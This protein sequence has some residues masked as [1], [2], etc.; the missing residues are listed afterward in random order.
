MAS[1]SKHVPPILLSWM[2]FLCIF[3]AVVSVRFHTHQNQRHRLLLC[4]SMYYMYFSF[5]SLLL[6]PF[7]QIQ[8]CLWLSADLLKTAVWEW[9]CVTVSAVIPNREER[10]CWWRM[11]K[12][13]KFTF[14]TA[15]MS[16]VL[17]TALVC[18]HWRVMQSV[19]RD[20]EYS[21]IWLTTSGSDRLGSN[22]WLVQLN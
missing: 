1:K 10:K 21:R 2:F 22:N 16:K 18:L 6:S 12:L 15:H 13:P 14:R 8:R 19:Q 9:K 20:T 4:Q 5:T 11:M 7:I 17:G 3:T